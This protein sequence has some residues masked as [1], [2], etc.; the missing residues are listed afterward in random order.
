M[1]PNSDDEK[2]EAADG[3]SAANSVNAQGQV[4]IEVLIPKISA[5]EDI[6]RAD[7]LGAQIA[8]SLS[9]AEYVPLGPQRLHT[10]ELVYKMV[11]LRKEPIYDALGRS[12]VFQRVLELIKTYAWNNFLQLKVIALFEEV[13]NN[14]ENADFKK[15]VLTGS[16]VGKAIIEMSQTPSYTMTSE[17]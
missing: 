14:C 3:S 5:V 6:L 12:A 2:D 10:V 11:C 16:G 17:K 15:A 4:L 7:Q 13:L 1:Q 8:T 9:N